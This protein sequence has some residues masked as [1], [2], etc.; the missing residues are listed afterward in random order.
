MGGSAEPY[1]NNPMRIPAIV[2]EARSAQKD[3][4]GFDALCRV[5]DYT[6][7][8]PALAIDLLRVV[9]KAVL[10][11]LATVRVVYPVPNRVSQGTAIG[12]VNSYLKERTG[13]SRLQAVAVALFRA[14]G[15][16]YGQFPTVRSNNINAADAST[17]SAADLECVAANGRIV[18]AVEVKDRQLA[19]L[20]V[21]VKL[22]MLREKG[23]T[24]AIF[25]V[26]GGTVPSDLAEIMAL[27]DKEFGS[28][29][30]IYVAD[31][32]RFLENH[33]I[34][35]GEDGRRKFLQFVGNELDAQNADIGHRRLWRDLLAAI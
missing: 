15:E 33:L 5:L 3:K 20:H 29:Q 24:E 12:C 7:E 28:G 6:Q 25:I 26:Q 9:L 13:G 11:R 22:S 31:F 32:M 17:G 16:L 10:A 14:I 35:F 2:P 34:V 4:P 19:L 30:N 8:N 23:I 1:A 27:I 18:K 21:Q